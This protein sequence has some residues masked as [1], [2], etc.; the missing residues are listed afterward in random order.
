MWAAIFLITGDV[1]RDVF[2]SPSSTRIILINGNNSELLYK[3][4][5][6]ARE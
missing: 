5:P 3:Y 1:I 2:A 6:D 4:D